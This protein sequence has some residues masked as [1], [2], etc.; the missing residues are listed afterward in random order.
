M[1]AFIFI[2]LSLFLGLSLQKVT[3]F[4]GAGPFL[5]R[6]V[7][8]VSLPAFVLAKIPPLMQSSHALESTWVGIVAT[9]ALMFS[10]GLGFTWLGRRL[11][12]PENVA[13]CVTL[14]VGFGNTSFLG[15]PLLES[16]LGKESLQYAIWVD[17]LGTFLGLATYGM[18]LLHAKT[19]ISV[20]EQL[21]KI[22]TFPP[23]VALV[24]AACWGLF[25]GTVQWLQEIL[26]R[27]SATLAPL[28]ILSV[29]LQVRL[30]HFR[31]GK[32]RLP[33][34]LAL[35]WKLIIF[36][37]L[38]W[39]LIRL[40]GPDMTGLAGRVAVL[41]VG[42]APMITSV[43]LAVEAGI[44]PELALALLGAGVPLSLLTVPLWSFLLQ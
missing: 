19:K 29:G 13:T 33:F 35:L 7:I 31:L 8:W 25:G 27:W 32:L 22:L 26:E 23:F 42:M 6:I 30:Q 18:F 2:L 15:F 16:L 24:L 39:S 10:T 14:S 3:G 40:T 4:R 28:S 1:T 38:I 20:P 5:T 43:L 41:E 21:R 37:A 9:W 11:Q 34:A 12:W 17:Q 44:V 36:P